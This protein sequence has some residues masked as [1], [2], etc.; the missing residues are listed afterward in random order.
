MPREPR[1]RERSSYPPVPDS[2]TRRT[3]GAGPAGCV[4][5]PDPTRP[6]G[7]EARHPGA[8]HH[9]FSDPFRG[10]Q[11]FMSDRRKPSILFV[12]LGNICRSPLAEGVL[13]HLLA[14]K[15]LGDDYHVASGGTGGWHAGEPPDRRSADVARRNGVRLEGTARQ[16]TPADL[17]RFDWI[18]AM[19]QGNLADLEA[20]HRRHG[21]RARLLRLREFDPDPEDGDVPDPYYEGP[22]GFDHVYHV[23]RRSVEVFLDHLESA[24]HEE[25]EREGGTS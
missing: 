12:C 4:K 7:P 24:A 9:F 11:S 25:D 15:G 19:D 8:V 3:G 20:L 6:G 13:R 10:Y 16:V 14:E 17:E 23:V 22:Q 5:R 21:G 1:L 2:C 18:V